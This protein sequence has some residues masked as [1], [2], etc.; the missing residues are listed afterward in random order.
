MDLWTYRAIDI[1]APLE[2]SGFEVEAIDGSIGEIGEASHE[3]GDSYIVVDTGFWIF[4][5]K[6]IVPAAMID[7]IDLNE[8]KVYINQTRDEVKSAP[9]WDPDTQGTEAFRKAVADYY[10]RS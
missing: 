9:D 7:R 8:R 4:G 1:T 3:P 5:K 6:R 10:S 2:L